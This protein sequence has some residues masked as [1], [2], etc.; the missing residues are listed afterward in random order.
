MKSELPVECEVRWSL[1]GE[2]LPEVSFLRL[3]APEQA[4]SEKER[5]ISQF[6]ETVWLFITLQPRELLLAE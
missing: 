4:P 2:V 3:N 5:T 1:P 6:M